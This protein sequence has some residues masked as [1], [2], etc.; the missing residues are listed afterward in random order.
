MELAQRFLIRLGMFGFV[1]FLVSG[2]ESC[3]ELKFSMGAKDATAHVT[4]I[5]EK[6][7]DSGRS[8]GWIVTYNF[9]ND[10]TKELQK[11][12][13]LVGS[14]SV[15]QF[16]EGQDI[17]I[18]YC[19]TS[20]LDSRIKGET[21]KTWVYVFLGSLAFCVAAVAILSWQSMQE[22]KRGSRKR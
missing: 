12:Y 14:D 17:P 9:H 8:L 22:E 2:F 19:G 4:K 13:T 20:Q 11:G 6:T 1:I 16:T 5:Y 18:E 7:N 15:G 3:S 21:N 10:D